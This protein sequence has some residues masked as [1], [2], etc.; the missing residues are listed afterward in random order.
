M[1]ATTKLTLEQ[2]LALPDTEP[3]SEYVC[4]EVLQKPMP[5]LA[6]SLLQGFLL[7]VLRQFL[8]QTGLGQAG[9][10]LRC[11]FGPPGQ[12]RAFVPDI[13]FVSRQRLPRGDAR[14][15]VQFR[16][17]PDLAIEILS[18]GQP[19]GRFTEKVQFYL[20][21]GVQ[22]VWV[23]DPAAETVTEL[24]PDA[25]PQTLTLSDMLTGGD[26]LPGLGV[27]VADVFAQLHL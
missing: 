7:V 3:A 5:G 15:T 6:H 19:V 4:G 18:P 12:E 17:A 9:P 23:V 20:R 25:D 13:A 26:V 2:F 8:S 21:H 22:L 11:I 1:T 16:A 10:E 14:D 24:A 27:A